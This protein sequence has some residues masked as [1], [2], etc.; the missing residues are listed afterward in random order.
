MQLGRLEH[1]DPV[2]VGIENL[3]R[4]AREFVRGGPGHR[5]AAFL[6][7]RDRLV[8]RPRGENGGHL[9]A[10]GYFAGAQGDELQEQRAQRELDPV[11]LEAAAFGEA[12]S[13]AVKT[14]GARKVTC[15]NMNPPEGEEHRQT[16]ETVS[17]KGG[18]LEKVPRNRWR[19]PSAFLR[20]GGSRPELI[21]ELGFYKEVVEFSIT[22]VAMTRLAAG[23]DPGA[24]RGAEF[25]F[26][27][28]DAGLYCL[29]SGATGRKRLG[30]MGGCRGDGDGD[31]SHLQS[32]NPMAENDLGLWICP[33][34][35]LGDAG[36][37]AFG[38]GAVGL[39][40]EAVHA[41]AVVVVPHD[42]YEEGQSPVAIPPHGGEERPR[43][44]GGIREEGHR[45]MIRPP[46]EREPQ[47]RR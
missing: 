2:A 30:P 31:I 35:L 5:D 14:A 18:G 25:A 4:A 42:A 8:E 12:E 16:S 3:R 28:R 13:L 9:I 27:D 43:I 44:D 6:E 20:P 37:F 26:P 22:F 39:V 15:G 46:P 36:H 21:P 10:R 24:S 17:R 23:L 19:S 45:N 32:S 1:D 29:D 40:L 7:L 34:K 33:G 11:A 38:H 47:S 41:A